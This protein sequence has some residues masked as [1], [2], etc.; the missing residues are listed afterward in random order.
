M[1]ET[2]SRLSPAPPYSRYLSVATIMGL[3]GAFFW[4]IRG[5]AGYGG[6][7]GAMLAGLGW[8]VLWY[9]FANLDGRGKERAY[10][11]PRMLAAITLGIAFG[12]L[13]GYGVYIAWLQGRFY[14]D[15]PDG[16]RAIAPWTGY[17]MLFF[18]G[19]H[20][21]GVA[22]AFMAWCAPAKP[23]T[24]VHWIWRLAAGIAGALAAGWLVHAFPQWFL[25]FY[26]EGIYD[27]PANETC[28]RAQGSI[29]NIAPHVGLFLGF[30]GF[31][32][33]RRDWRAVGMMTVMALGFAIPFSAGG[34]WQTLH[35]TGPGIDWWKQWEMSIGLGGG[36]ALGLA[37]YL[38]NKPISKSTTRQ[39]SAREMVWGGGLPL[40]LA[41]C[42]VFMGACEG[43]L[44]M[45]HPEWMYP[46]RGVA[47]L[48]YMIGTGLCLVWWSNRM[49]K[50]SGSV[51]LPGW[52]L[53]CALVLIVLSGYAVSTPLPLLFAN[54]VLL[55]LY[56]FYLG[57]SLF[58]FYLM[59]RCM[60]QCDV[61]L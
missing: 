42:V 28:L 14:L 52:I 22:G 50:G 45:H 44:D 7:Q 17:A 38:F 49:R 36:L 18:C 5:S 30:L 3:M 23:V 40:W 35:D 2:Q 60:R 26:S 1:N 4:A 11:S 6:S 29:G 57:A 39:V 46:V 58:Q 41:G 56:T 55:S 10:A 34:Y 9:G 51:V 19:L 20:W 27:V 31:E 8:A 25:P 33:T 54:K 12:G 24:W 16:V 53:V 21:G 37:F 59:R 13:T 61:P 32:A 43:L 47:T 48:V 15:Y